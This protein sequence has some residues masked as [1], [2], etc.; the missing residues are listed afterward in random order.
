MKVAKIFAKRTGRW[1]S[2][3]LQ[4]LQRVFGSTSNEGIARILGRSVASIE[5]Q[6]KRRQLA[7]DKVFVKRHHG[8]GVYKMPHWDT[9]QVK[10][11]RLIYANL[12]NLEVAR[13]LKRSVAS[14][15][16]KA[17]ALGLRKSPRRVEQMGRENIRGRWETKDRQIK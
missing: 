13:R 8:Q 2:A 12:S 1:T 5:R 17:H 16:Y 14:V 15:V 7:K 4:Q 3:E 11:L 6:A 9:D 10:L